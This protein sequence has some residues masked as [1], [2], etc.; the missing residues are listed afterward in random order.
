MPRGQA[1]AEGQH[2]GAAVLV[3]HHAVQQEVTGGIHGR[4]E[5]ED[6]PQ[7]QHDGFGRPAQEVRPN[8]NIGVLLL[9]RFRLEIV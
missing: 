4:Q 9:K 2:E 6:V 7:T 5:V 1:G 3:A 8:V